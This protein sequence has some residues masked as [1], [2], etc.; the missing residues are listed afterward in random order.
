MKDE[1]KKFW[2]GDIEDS[3]E[4]LTK[5]SHDASLL[6]IRPELVVFPKDSKDL[7]E[8]VKWVRA[9][10]TKYPRVA[11]TPRSADRKSVV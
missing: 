1:I 10:K 8:L 9:N 7:Q 5:Y 11:L 6:E 4:T 3:D 2:R